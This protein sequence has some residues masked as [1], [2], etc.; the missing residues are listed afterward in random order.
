[1]VRY[2][3]FTEVE[4]D[5]TYRQFLV[6]LI[7]QIHQSQRLLEEQLQRTQRLCEMAEREHKLDQRMDVLPPGISLH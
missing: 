3:L 7:R 5:V 2:R 6:E 1:M 4:S